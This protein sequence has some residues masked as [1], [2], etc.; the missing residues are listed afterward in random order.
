MLVAKARLKSMQ[1]PL[2]DRWYEAF[3][4]TSPDD[5]RHHA[6][7][8]TLQLREFEENGGRLPESSGS[9]SALRVAMKG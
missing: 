2:F 9:V 7:S 5:Q 6:T 4:R 8:L 3:W 1:H